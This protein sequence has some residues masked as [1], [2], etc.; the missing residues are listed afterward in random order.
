MDFSSS[1]LS[2][3]VVLETII[4]LVCYLRYFS[5]KNQLFYVFL[6]GVVQCSGFAEPS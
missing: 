6:S 1:F 2:S 3:N 5:S 4:G